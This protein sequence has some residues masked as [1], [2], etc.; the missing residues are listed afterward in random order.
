[1][2]AMNKTEKTNIIDIES[3]SMPKKASELLRI[4]VRPYKRK[5]VLFFMLTFVGILAWTASPVIISIIVTRLGE[6]P[7]VDKYIWTLVAI[8]FGLRIIDEVLWRLSELLMRSYKPQMIE[9]LR[10]ILFKETLK[11]PHEFYINSS[12]GRIGHWINTATQTTNDMVD[13][14]IWTVWGRIIGLIM[15]AVFLFFVHWSLALLFCVWLVLLFFYNSR[16]GKTFSKLVAKQSDEASKAS[17]IVV[18]SLSNHLSVRVFN[19]RHHERQRLLNQQ[20]KIIYSWRKS[21]WQNLITNVVKGQ[22]AAIVSTLALIL[23]LVLFA[24]GTVALGGVVLFVAYFGDASSSLWQLAWALDTYYRS[25]GTIQNSLDGLQSDT[26]RKGDIVPTED[27]PE[28]VSLSL[29][30][31]D[32]AYPDQPKEKILEDINFVVPAGQKIGVVGH[33]GAG[34][35]TL[36]GLLLGFYSPTSGSILVNDI[37]VASKDPSFVRSVSSFVPQD[38]NL[39]NRTIR[40]NVVYARPDATEKEI[41]QALIQAEALEFVEKLPNGLETLIGERGIKLSGGQR[42]RIAIARAILK[43]A[44]LLLLDEATSALDSVSEQA[45]QKALHDLMKG[46]TSI[47][48]AHRLSTLKHLD[49]IIVIEKGCIA[50]QGTHEELVKKDGIYADLWKRQKDGFIVD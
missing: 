11:K 10:T 44:P 15:S 8:Y 31:L 7:T 46:R 36:V 21:W 18:D 2:G 16:R 43:N 9:R 12:S 26:E 25:F 6:N 37:D 47:V 4:M 23:V 24:N 32:F 42:Q 29:Q 20:S 41:K 50:E 45:I 17:G 14:T 13:M 3:I 34:K 48:I 39:F 49:K 5:T 28:E 35:S 1:M 27:M 38:T 19:A 40:E 22:S 33:S 30:S